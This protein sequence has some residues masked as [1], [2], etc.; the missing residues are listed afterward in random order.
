MLASFAVYLTIISIFTAC[1]C[2]IQAYT[3][4]RKIQFLSKETLD[5]VRH[6]QLLW[7]IIG[8]CLFYILASIHWLVSEY[9]EAV[10]EWTDL[11]WSSWGLSIFC[12]FV[13]IISI[14]SKQ[15]TETA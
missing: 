11:L 3:G 14:I 5:S 1:Y 6:K 12:F 10:G 2:I 4:I 9:T 7:W 8:L 13:R 15:T